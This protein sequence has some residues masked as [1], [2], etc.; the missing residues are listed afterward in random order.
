MGLFEGKSKTE[1]NKLIAAGVLGLVAIISLYLA[2][3]RSFFGGSSTTAAKPK[4][5]PSVKATPTTGS[6]TGDRLLPTVDEQRFQYETTEVSY[7]PG[8]AYAPDPGRN[9]FAF[10]EPPPPCNPNKPGDCPTPTP[11][12]I[13]A[14]KTPEPPPPPP[15]LLRSPIPQNIYAGSKAFKLQVDGDYFTPESRIYFNQ[16]A[17]PTT[18][19]SPQRLSAEIPANLIAQEGSRQIMVQTPDGRL[20]SNPVN[21]M[22]NPPPKPN[23]EYIGMIGRKRYNNDTAYFIGGQSPNPYGARLN[24]VVG[25]QFRLID[26]SPAEVVFQD[27]NLGFKH[28]LVIAKASASSNVPGGIPSGIQGIP[29]NIPRYV[30]PVPQP[31]GKRPVEKKEDVDDKDDPPQ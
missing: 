8:N 21:L 6:N 10:Y 5:T 4:A 29:P 7:V 1:R 23:F 9:I 19:F 24:D 3:G 27:V 18:F 15:I 11:S 13:P 22:V 26:I 28:R 30:P 17:M 31:Q 16:T 2:F 12:P 20:Y 14:P 25:G